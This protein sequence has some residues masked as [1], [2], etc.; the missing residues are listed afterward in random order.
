MY[1]LVADRDASERG[2]IS[3]LLVSRGHTV[4]TCGTQEAAVEKLAN[5]ETIRSAMCPIMAPV[6][7]PSATLERSSFVFDGALSIPGTGAGS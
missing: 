1:I 5:D 6:K 3:A 2:R 7:G 4:V